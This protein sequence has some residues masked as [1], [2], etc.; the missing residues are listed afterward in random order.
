MLFKSFG[1]FIVACLVLLGALLAPHQA[2]TPPVQLDF[3]F[4]SGALDWQAGFADLPA[5]NTGFYD[6]QSGIRLL[7]PEL[8]VSGTGFYI[9]GINHSDDLFMF[10]KRRLTVADGIVAGQK[11][12]ARYAIDFASE[13]QVGCASV[14]GAPGEA[15]YLKAGATPNEPLSLPQDEGFIQLRMN[16]NTGAQSVGGSAASTSGNIANGLPCNLQQRPFVSVHRVYEHLTQ[17]TA[18]ANGEMWLLLG[19]DS[20]FEERT[21]LYYQRIQVELIPVG[22]PALAVPSIITENSTGRAVALNSVTMLRDPFRLITTPR[23]SSDQRT[24]LMLFVLN[25]DL[26]PGEDRSVF[27]AQIEGMDIVA[28]TYPLTVEYVGKVPGVDSLTQIVLRLPDELDSQEQ[29]SNWWISLK[30]RGAES[31]RAKI[32]T[33]FVL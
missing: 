16:V 20:G 32:L 33:R 27:S 7:P 6:L 10:L 19:T 26:L 5:T 18:A 23:F 30:L 1:K 8:G 15:V 9:Q 21:R 25:A 13:A 12:R 14:G 11:Y 4:R 29:G 31:N 28:E 22:S 3:D 17:V 24:R 2:Q